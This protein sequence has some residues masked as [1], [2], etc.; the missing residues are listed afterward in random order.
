MT[1]TTPREDAPLEAAALLAPPTFLGALEGATVEAVAQLAREASKPEVL[2]IPTKGLGRGLPDTVPFLWDRH[3]QKAIPVVKE[4]LDARPPLERMGSAAVTTLD[5]FIELVNRHKDDG[6]AI[7]AR[8]I[9]MKPSLQAVIDY[10]K[11]G[12][13]HEARHCRHRIVYDFPLTDEFKAWVDGDGKKLPQVEFATFIEDHA[14][15]LSAPMDGEVTEY[16]LLFKESFASPAE[17]I[18]LSRNLEVYEG[19][20]VKQG[21]RLQSGE[22][23]VI[24]TTEHTNANGDPIDIPGI[25]MVSVAPFFSGEAEPEKVRIPARIRYRIAGGAIVWFYQLY[26]WEYFL[27]ERVQQDAAFAAEATGLPCYEGAPETPPA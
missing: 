9:G 26:R 22:R 19:A 10:H 7:F 13:T 11:A 3:A 18:D 14:A 15:E 12:E 24:F 27:R 23:Q 2:Q 21:A 16:E 20:K 5:S 8:S 25:F 6:S 4:I 1:Q 17:L